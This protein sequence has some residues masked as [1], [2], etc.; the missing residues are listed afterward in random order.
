MTSW[1]T[2]AGFEPHGEC[3]LWTPGLIMLHVVSDA[4][5]ALAY[6]SIPV[7]LVYF[8][9]RRADLPFGALFWMFGVFIVACGTTHVL[10]IYEIWHG[11]YWL[12]GTVK[13]ITALASV[14]TAV[15]LVPV[16]P[17]ALKLKS[18]AELDAINRRLTKSL[19]EKEE[20][21][22][23]Y[24][25]E[26]RVA[27]VL[28]D[29][30][31]PHD[32]PAEP[33]LRFDAVY[34]PGASESEIGGDWYDAFVRHDGS[35]FISIGDVSGRGLDA[36]VTMGKV[37]QALRTLALR[38]DD[39]DEILAAADM[40]LRTERPDAMAT[41]LVALFDPKSSRLTYALAGHPAPLMRAPD[42]TVVE[43]AA[44][45][46]LPLGLRTG[47][48]PPPVAVDVAPGSVIAFFTDGLLEMDRDVTAGLAAVRAELAGP[49]YEP[50]DDPGT[51]L[52]QQ[53]TE[54]LLA[55]K[56]PRDDIA[57]LMMAVSGD[58]PRTLSIEL[59]ALPANARVARAALARYLRRAGLSDDAVFRAEV[60]A[61]EAVMNAIEH[62]YSTRPG[63]FCLSASLDADRVTI[64][65]RDEGSWRRPREDGRG[66]GLIIMREMCDTVELRQGDGTAGSVVRFTLARTPD[67]ERVG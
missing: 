55:G 44:V 13:A 30:S 57:V 3:Y 43:L 47:S 54:A 15:V 21:L 24:Q 45:A 42:G 35:V 41:A 26:R 4:L 53:L 17:A 18:P 2:G 22:H 5:I 39:T 49:R 37:R 28:Q 56:T 12:S 9:Y 34:R 52:A 32:L 1:F 33:G 7:A 11:A 23:M 46:G 29:A 10:S 20:L 58:A 19:A 25:R 31:L 36:A 50:A 38:M 48:E 14:A 66:R 59:P 61:G 6:Y 60:A 40:V 63:S 62:A 27:S 51:P 16:I 8:V 64:E 67:E 65:V